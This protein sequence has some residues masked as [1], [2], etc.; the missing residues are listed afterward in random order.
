[1]VKV[2][3][4]LNV[5]LFGASMKKALALT[6]LAA[7]LMSAMAGT[8]LVN[9]TQAN[10]LHVREGPSITI[11]SPEQ[12]TYNTHMIELHIAA[13][14]GYPG[15]SITMIRY[16]VD[17]GPFMYLS[18]L[19]GANDA[20][21]GTTLNLT[22]GPHDIL[23]QLNTSRTQGEVAVCTTVTFLI[24]TITP[25]LILLSPENKTYKSDIPLDFSAFKTSDIRYSLD[26]QANVSV[27][28]A[29]TLKDVPDGPHG[30]VL[31]GTSDAGITY[32]PD[33]VFFG[34]DTGPPK[35]TVS[36]PLEYETYYAPTIP[37]TFSVSEPSPLISYS[38]DGHRSVNVTGNATLT[39]LSV[40]YH[41]LIFTAQD[42]VTNQ[43]GY[44]EVHFSIE[45]EPLSKTLVPVVTVAA[46][47]TILLGLLV[48]ILKRK[49]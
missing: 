21:V 11:Y 23:A 12:K 30:L 14:D 41:V 22:D 3:G 8:R 28:G 47:D 31:F 2:K 16:S 18:G 6:L 24:N 48:Y 38:L 5:L 45:P 25:Y 15:S 35:V 33:A 29:T 49:R 42:S 36:W 27:T 44:A 46:I 43:Q 37:L 40:G 39:E 32:T 7:L 19:R 20:N 13:Y 26:G 9:M 4:T 1:M 10:P 34:V 17:S